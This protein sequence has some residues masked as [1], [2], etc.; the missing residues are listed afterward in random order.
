MPENPP[1]GMPRVTP[2]LLY[3]D[4]AAALDWL[5]AAFGF[6]EALRYADAEGT[7][8]HAEMRVDDDGVVFMG[9]PGPEFR[10]P[11][12]LGQ[13][14]VHVHV[15]VDDV[16][17]HFEQAKA[18]GATIVME[19]VDEPY[20]DRRYDAEDPEGVRWSFAQRMRD[21]SPEEW[22]ATEP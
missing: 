18:A 9:H 1:R 16:D 17:S 13:P 12:H 8:S 3:E 21:V 15:Y 22:G 7:V 11:K 6:A 14:T 4:V 5:A 19:P 20:G 2:Y 10:N